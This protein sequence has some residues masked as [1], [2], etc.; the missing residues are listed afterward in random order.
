MDLTALT[1]DSPRPGRVTNGTSCTHSDLGTFERDGKP[2]R[3]EVTRWFAPEVLGG[4]RRVS[5]AVVIF[6]KGR[7]VPERCLK[8]EREALARHGRIRVQDAAT[9][10]ST[11]ENTKG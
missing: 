6:H 4:R 10:W 9:F 8:A 2:Y 5:Y 3:F 11:Q 7:A 1:W